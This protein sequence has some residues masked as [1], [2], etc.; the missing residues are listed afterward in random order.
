M[1]S[2]KSFEPAVMPVTLTSVPRTPAIVAG[3]TRSRSV[4]SAASDSAS[5]PSPASGMSTI[6]RLPR[7]FVVVLIGR[8]KPSVS[9]AIFCSSAIPAWTSGALMSSAW[10]TTDAGSGPPGNFSWMRS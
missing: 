4:A 7:G 9:P 2:L 1:V 6:S 10:T 8:P 3:T 5:V